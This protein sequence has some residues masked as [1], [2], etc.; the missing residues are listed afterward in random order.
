MKIRRFIGTNHE[1]MSVPDYLILAASK[2]SQPPGTENELYLRLEC[3]FI[4]NIE[5]EPKIPEFSQQ[6]QVWKYGL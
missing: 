3:K 2:F 5:F 6:I 4:V 1:K